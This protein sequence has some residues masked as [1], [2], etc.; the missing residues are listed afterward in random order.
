MKTLSFRRLFVVVLVAI[1]VLPT[2]QAAKTNFF[3]SFES[4][5]AN[6]VVGDTNPFSAPAYWGIVNSAFGGE[7][8]RSGSFKAYCAGIGFVG[9]ASNPRYQN[10][11]TAFLSRTVDL[12]TYTNAVLSFYYKMPSIEADYD[13]A[14]VL[15]DDVEIW[16]SSAPATTW[17]LV[18][19]D[20]EEFIGTNRT[21]TFQFQSDYSITNEGW[22]LD[23]ILLTDLGVPKP[24]PT[25]D[26]FSAAQLITG[27]VGSFTGTTRSAT[28]EGNEPHPGNS[29]WYKWTAPTNGF[30]TFR[31]AG[32]AFDTVLCVYTGNSL[33][34]LANVG[35]N[36]NGDTNGASVL[37]FN[38]SSGVNYSISVRGA[39]N[40]SGF[41]VL[42]WIQTNGVRPELLPDLI[43]WTNVPNE[44][45]YGWYI[46]Q[47]EPTQPNR[48]LMRVST[49]T[50]NIGRGPLELRGSSDGPTVQQRIY[51]VDGTTY[52]RFAG[53]FSFHPSH[54]HLHFDNWVNLHLRAVLPG[55]GVG[56]IVASGDKTSFAIIDL[57]PYNLSLS[58]ASPAAVYNDGGLIQGLSV[59]WA[60]V[61]S[62]ELPDQ[63]I[64]VSGVPSGTYWLEAIVDPDNNIVELNE[65]NNVARI[66]IDYV[67]PPPPNLTPPPNDHFTN[68]SP[69]VGITG[70]DVGLNSNATRESGEPIHV[71]PSSRSVW[72]R[73]TA[74]SN[75]TAVISTDGSS[76][77]TLLA[78]YTGTN[79]SALSL[80]EDDDDGG[81]NANSRVTF[82]ATQGV[83]YRIAVDGYANDTGTVQMN[84]NPALNDA[85][86]NCLSLTGA[87][88]FVTGSTR[89]ATRQ[90]GEPLHG[91]STGTGS[92]WYCWTAPFG[93]AFTFDTGGSSFD[94]L[95]GIYTGN[96]VN[97]LTAIALDDNSSSNGAS[98]VVFN[99]IGGV[100][101]RIAVD[102]T[103]NPGVVKLT[104]SG[105]LPPTMV[106]QPLSTNAPA[107]ATVSFSV[108]VAGTP[109][110]GFQ[111]RHQGTNLVDDGENISGA[112]S[113]VLMLH[114][115]LPPNMGAYTVVITNAS[116]AITSAPANLIVL[117]NPR[118]VYVPPVG[119]HLNGFV[120]VPVELQAVGGEH[121][122]NFSLA[123]VP[124]VLSQP[125]ATN[126]HSGSIL[127][128]DTNHVASGKLG[129]TVTRL[130]GQ[131][132]S[133]G[134]FVLV[135][136]VFQTPAGNSPIQTQA[137]LGNSPVA[138][139]VVDANFDPLTTLFVA[140]TV[141][142]LPPVQLAGGVFSN[143]VYRLPF[144]AAGAQRYVIE[145]SEDLVTWTPL[146]TNS[147]SAGP[148]QFTD[149]TGLPHR[150]YKVRLVP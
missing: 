111:W 57:T 140:G 85:F 5:L 15:I 120:R 114:K 3:E 6:W 143:G 87:Q 35:C 117:D 10:E 115:I 110:F 11:M 76:F 68:A 104:W 80:I 19:L 122:V 134:Q 90:S 63:W 81:E 132:F 8:T 33:P 37:T 79:L 56:E 116:G 88:G 12:T 14:I 49:A 89:G 92:V 119:G 21:L 4:T 124:S 60:D 78:I 47:D 83:T 82:A 149:T 108:S 42:S 98:R 66:L 84:V 46:D 13:Y 61:Y 109:P 118:V 97:A 95:L 23:D 69:I 51:R 141:N 17:T 127:T 142:L 100:T 112:N 40:A 30:V 67:V 99:A 9:T 123:F 113:P 53:N 20:L 16:Y 91:A 24:P 101:Y 135:E 121:S 139:S 77:D 128:L 44:Y 25:N 93:G 59:G 125:R 148:Y 29:V 27:A 146:A 72:W 94:T 34:S 7:G 45:L 75:M 32:S 129:V 107:G 147:P 2:A 106:D 41:L 1:G 102:G 103:T 52:D 55:G 36:D 126:V 86:A 144:V 54:G 38:A 26:N 138:R 150:F 31:T 105:P 58:N 71:S 43:V 28:A 130:N 70:G 145:A 50:P 18:T 65:T 133:P 48:T 73:W 136:F 74:P 62:A 39:S 64:D 96:A 22:Y 131:T 137:G